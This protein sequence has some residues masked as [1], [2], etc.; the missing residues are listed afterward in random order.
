M[1]LPLRPMSY[2]RISQIGRNP[3]TNIMDI[4]TGIELECS[5]RMAMN[6][7]FNC[8]M[9]LEQLLLTRL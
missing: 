8:K 1:Q 7:K 5:L 4:D 3:T 9:A 6:M 2:Y